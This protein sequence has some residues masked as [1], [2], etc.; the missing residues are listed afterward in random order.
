MGVFGKK[1]RRGCWETAVWMIFSFTQPSLACLAVVVSLFVCCLCVIRSTILI[2]MTNT[3]TSQAKP[4]KRPRDGVIPPTAGG[5]AAGRTPFDPSPT[6][7]ASS[8]SASPM[9]TESRFAS[10]NRFG[11]FAM[12]EDTNSQP[13]LQVD[14]TA[15]KDSSQQENIENKQSKLKKKKKKPSQQPNRALASPDDGDES[16][17]GSPANHSHRRGALTAQEKQEQ[18]ERRLHRNKQATRKKSTSRNGDAVVDAEEDEELEDEFDPSF[19]DKQGQKNNATNK[20][21]QKKQQPQ[22]AVKTKKLSQNQQNSSSASA[23]TE[24]P[25]ANETSAIS[26]GNGTKAQSTEDKKQAAEKRA[27]ENLDK[28]DKILIQKMKELQNKE[29]EAHKMSKTKT[30][31]IAVG[32]LLLL[33]FVVLLRMNQD[34]YQNT[35]T[36]T[37]EHRDEVNYYELLGLERG[38]SPEAIKKAYRK[39]VQKWHPDRNPECGQECTDKMTE[40]SEAYDILSYPETRLWH[41]R[42]GVKPPENMIKI[43]RAKYGGKHSKN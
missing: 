23:S 16:S 43:A 26:N 20:Q 18:R 39:L 29:R 40:L 6:S 35:H 5:G 8:A 10:Q 30:I 12:D 14:S 38:A 37:G 32:V 27:I 33:A 41:D 3:K 7:S 11:A 22:A 1:T 19:S 31:F 36:W 28:S 4:S 13:P 17:E 2:A 34:A 42:Y 25:H 9:T 15:V 24:S 21:A